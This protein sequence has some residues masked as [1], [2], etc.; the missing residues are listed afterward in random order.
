MLTVLVGD[1]DALDEAGYKPLGKRYFSIPGTIDMLNTKHIG[2]TDSFQL[3][4]GSVY[5]VAGIT[6]DTEEDL[7]VII[8]QDTKDLITML[9]DKC[10]QR[11]VSHNVQSPFRD[12]EFLGQLRLCRL[13][14]HLTAL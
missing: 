5:A 11:F 13:F 14:S 1:K 9:V 3:K 8:E 6:L 10:L 4:L 12:L 2:A 7:A